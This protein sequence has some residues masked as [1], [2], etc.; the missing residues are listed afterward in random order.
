MLKAAY[1]KLFFNLDF[2]PKDQDHVFAAFA[3]RIG[4]EIS[5]GEASAR[6][7]MDAVRSHMRILIGLSGHLVTTAAPSEPILAVA[8]AW[9]L[10]SSTKTYREA[11]ET[12]LGKI[13]LRGLIIDRGIQGELYSRLLLTLARDKAVL[14]NG[15]EFT[16]RS[17]S[18]V[19]EVQA[20]QLS[21]FLQ[22]LLGQNLGIPANEVEQSELC[23]RLLQD[24]STVWINF[25]HFVQLSVS[26]SEVTPSMLREAWSSGY[27]FQCA[28]HQPVIDGLIVAYCGNLNDSFDPT[29][30]FVVPW[31]TKV[32]SQVSNL[33]LAR[34]LTAPFLRNSDLVRF[35]PRHVAIFM[36]LG[37]PSA[38][39]N[40]NGPHCQLSYSP[41]ERPKIGNNNAKG[42]DWDGY[43]MDNEIEAW[44]YCL[45]VRGHSTGTY[46]VLSGFVKQFDLLFQ[47]SLTCAEM[48][49]AM[50]RSIF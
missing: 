44:R 22:T 41:A 24:M 2:D 7:A 48:E 23:Y 18:N 37:A 17:N 12:L 42:A 15:G 10:N 27:A 31:Q 34:Q 39:K 40:A 30:L 46:P 4:L 5:E 9:A 19:H 28:F 47:R 16:K 29:N 49:G 35:K 14:P 25:T 11:I 36:D 33:D 43:A 50:D 21:R 32:T 38:F 45:N 1:D 6:L 20:V 26:I 3:I 13:I 8:A